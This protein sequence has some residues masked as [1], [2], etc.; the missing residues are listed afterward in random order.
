MTYG[1]LLAHG[2]PDPRSAR[3]VACAAAGAADRAGFPV[4]GAFLDHDAPRLDAAVAAAAPDDE[5]VVLPLLLS[6]AF[7]ARVDVPAAAAALPRAV[8]LLDPL[9][10]PP[11]VL[12]AALLRAGAACVVVAAGT[13]VDEER[14]AF[15]AAVAAASARAGVP[16]SV[17]FVTGPGARLT[18]SAP[19]T[20]VVPWLLAPGRLLD[21]VLAAAAESSYP[22][23]GGPLLDEPAMLDAI[24]ARLRR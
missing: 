15:G 17:A 20:V 11:E 23:V 16:A 9:G 2:S 3:W 4:V 18:D 19:G 24:A 5:V 14:A 13:K 10:H 12:D 1:V 8:T 21:S 7:H 6:A 22:V